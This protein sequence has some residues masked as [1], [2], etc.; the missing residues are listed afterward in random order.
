MQYLGLPFRDAVFEMLGKLPEIEIEPTSK[1]AY[2]PNTAT[3]QKRVIAYLCQRRGL[4]YKLVTEL[5]R[6][7][8]LR[9]D[10]NGNC[11]FNI[12]DKSGEL[13][14]AELHGTGE[15]RFKGQASPQDG[16][17]FEFLVGDSVEWCIYME[18]AIDLLSFYQLFKDQIH[19]TLLVSL[20]GIGKTSVIE[21]YLNSYPHPKVKH[22][23]AIDNDKK[24]DVFAHDVQIEHEYNGR[25]YIGRKIP[26]AKYKDWNDQLLD[27]PKD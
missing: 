5:I 4:D 10:T 3:N 26:D 24:A 19:N 9:Q 11:V 27:K 14:S 20:G 2:K 1:I 6:N 13:I 15:T 22:C 17:G 12:F 18:S 16:Y 23:L 7:G 8:K 21:H 25:K